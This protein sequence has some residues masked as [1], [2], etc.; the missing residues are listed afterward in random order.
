MSN[1]KA[2][3]ELALLKEKLK[4][5]TL[6]YIN[7]LGIVIDSKKNIHCLNPNH[8]DKNPSMHYWDAHNIF[9]CFSCGHSSDIFQIAHLKE[10]KP[11]YGKEFIL[12]NVFYLAKRFNEPYQHINID[13]SP[14]ERSKFR[15]YEIMRFLS[16]YVTAHQ[17]KA[18]LHQRNFKI[19]TALKLNIGSVDNY[20]NLLQTFIN[21]G[22]N[23]AEINAL[24][25]NANR[26][27]ENKLIFIIKNTYGQPV[28]FVSR[29]MIITIE[30]AT[31]LLNFNKKTEYDVLP[32][33]KSKELFLRS[34]AGNDNV[35]NTFINKFLIIGKYEN[36]TDS[37]IYSKKSIFYGYSD[38]RKQISSFE[39]VLI[40]EGYADFV[41][42]YQEGFRNI[43]ALGSASFTSEHLQIIE[44]AKEIKF[45]AITF[46]QDTTGMARAKS[47]AERIK[48]NSDIRKKYFIAKYKEGSKDLDEILAVK[49]IKSFDEIFDY[50]TLFQYAISNMLDTGM[51]E[52]DIVNQMIPMIMQEPSPLKRTELA[53]ELEKKLATINKFTI[54]QEVEYRTDNSKQQ[55]STLMLSALERARREISLQPE[56][57]MLLLDNAKDEIDKI[58]KS[59]FKKTKNIFELTEE[60]FNKDEEN[61]IDIRRFQTKWG[62]PI[63]ESM[64]IV[65]QK[66]ITVA[67]KPN[68]GK[69]SFFV[70]LV[71]NILMLNS[72][73]VVY[74]YTTDD[75]RADIKNNLMAA[76]SGLPRDYVTDP[77][78]HQYYGLNTNFKDKMIYH[79]A[80]NDVLAL[81]NKWVS[82]KRLAVLHSTDGSSDWTSFERTIKTDLHDNK[83]MEDCIKV[84]IIDSVNKIEVDGISGGNER[85]EFLSEHTKKTATKYDLV[86]FQN[87]EIRKVEKNQK[88]NASQLAG[89]RRIE[90][91]SDAII[92]LHQPM[93]E[94]PGMTK[95]YWQNSKYSSPIM[96]PTIIGEIEKSKIGGHKNMAY[97]HDLD[98]FCNQLITNHNPAELNI[99]KQEWYND[100]RNYMR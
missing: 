73:T 8:P 59:H 80:Y 77:I 16:D 32:D 66:V 57:A 86:L 81:I 67:A 33:K 9:Y 45:P 99:K 35:K 13:V 89:T 54:M 7:E 69:T 100:L 72:N 29:E 30:N 14:E 87:Y 34:K 94:L 4:F 62:I 65:P 23:E 40:V 20:G 50:E 90:Y 19:E 79:N 56:N 75:S 61:K 93:H 74:Y 22:F 6:Q 71:K 53:V 27:N 92:T 28:S 5:Y 3:E 64:R 78:N 39:K 36:G 42:A 76:I 41:S 82:Q 15:K 68:I 17:N 97:F 95:S 1:K 26:V 37:E 98:Y 88:I 46:D 63:L 48:E 21:N 31:K 24:G 91:D 12:D 52:T 55:I 51:S 25:I 10:G 43:V 2:N 85:A 96:M 58:S 60:G 84:L 18:F 70:N 83:E 11:L 44:E 49:K 47:L 38:V